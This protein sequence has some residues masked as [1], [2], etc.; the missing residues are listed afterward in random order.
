M[1]RSWTAVWTAFCCQ[2]IRS[3]WP[4]RSDWILGN[5]LVINANVRVVSIETDA[6]VGGALAGGGAV[7]LGTVKINPLIYGLNIGYKF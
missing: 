2:T 1:T 7:A 5:N 6:V 4:V 3:G